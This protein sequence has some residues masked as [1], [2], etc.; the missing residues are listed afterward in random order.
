MNSST[1]YIFF[2]IIIFAVIIAFTFG[3]KKRIGGWWSFFFLTFLAIIPGI[4]FIIIS[5]PKKKLIPDNPK[6]KTPNLVLGI[7]SIIIAV[8]SLYS[9]LITPE[10]MISLREDTRI[11]KIGLAIG[12]FGFAIYLFRRSERNKRLYQEQQNE[13][14]I[15]KAPF[16]NSHE[17]ANFNNSIR[18]GKE[19]E[20]KINRES[21]IIL[22][23]LIQKQ[24]KKVFGGGMNKEIQQQLSFFAETREEGN[25]LLNTYSTLFKKNLITELT[26]LNNS[27]AAIR[28]NVEIFIELGL[29]SDQFPHNRV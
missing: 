21:L 13:I 6:D 11:Y 22:N 1:V 23:Q 16:E 5:P 19:L 10:Y 26:K 29:V 9:A 28:E 20:G 18:S 15:L 27:Y 8:S 7:I 24:Q 25:L 14:N 2:P 12:F 4:L 3:E 17:I